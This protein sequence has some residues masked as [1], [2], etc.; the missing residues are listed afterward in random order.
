MNQPV[1]PKSDN[2]AAQKELVDQARRL[3]GVAEAMDVYERLVP[4]AQPYANVQ[5]SQLRNAT[6]GNVA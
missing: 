2:Q 6:G 3:P 5:S 1:H 4:Y